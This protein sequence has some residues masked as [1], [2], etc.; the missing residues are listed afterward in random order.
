MS[1]NLL[2]VGALSKS[3]TGY[4]A[5]AVGKMMQERNRFLLTLFVSGLIHDIIFNYINTL[6]KEIHWWALLILQIIPN[7]LYTAIVGVVIYY[8]FRSMAIWL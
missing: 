3:V 5:A 6:G 1:W 2:G 4:T 8:F 7:L